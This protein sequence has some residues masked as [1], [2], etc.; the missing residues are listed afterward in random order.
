MPCWSACVLG[1]EPHPTYTPTTTTQ[2]RRDAATASPEPSTV[3][4]SLSR[5]RTWRSI[6]R[7]S[8][9]RLTYFD[10]R[11]LAENSRLILAAAGQSDLGL[12]RSRVVSFV[13][14]SG[15]LGAHK[16]EAIG[17]VLLKRIVPQSWCEQHGGWRTCSSRV[18]IFINANVMHGNPIEP[19]WAKPSK[20]KRLWR[21]FRACQQSSLG[22]EVLI[23]LTWPSGLW[24]Q[25]H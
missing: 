25:P 20:T 14:N 7:R 23:G 15:G 2:H 6:Q 12:K 13:E 11:G 5:A 18:L 17:R 16:R 8:R 10:I 9:S 21:T 1:T 4:P 19:L 3:A 22:S 24:I